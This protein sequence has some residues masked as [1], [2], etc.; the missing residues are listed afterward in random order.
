MVSHTAC[1]ALHAHRRNLSDAQ[2]RRVAAAGGIIG[3]SLCPFFMA[4]GGAGVNL[5]TVVEHLLHALEVAGE[6]HVA[7]GTDLD[8]ISRL[9]SGFRGVADL[10]IIE[11]ELAA[12]GVAPETI[13]RIAWRN[14]ARLLDAALNGIDD[15]SG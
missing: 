5:R 9:P 14:A 12:C 15:E 2:L 13:S 11:A 6:R 8:G 4:P 10:P 3:I 7:L 1:A